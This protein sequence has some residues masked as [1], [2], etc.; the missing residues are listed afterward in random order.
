[1]R[2]LAGT[3]MAAWDTDALTRRFL[4]QAEDAERYLREVRS[5]VKSNPSYQHVYDEHMA[6]FYVFNYLHGRTFLETQ[7][8]LLRELRSLLNAKIPT[9]DI[10]DKERFETYRRRY[11]EQLIEEFSKEG[12]K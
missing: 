5:K 1:M 6:R 10:Y 7:D 2:T 11:I 12:T 8:S 3:A 4:H 9:P